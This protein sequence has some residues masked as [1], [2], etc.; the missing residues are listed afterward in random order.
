METPVLG[1]HFDKAAGLQLCNFIKKRFQH[2]CF[3][4]II[5]KFLGI[6]ILRASPNGCFCL[7]KQ[8]VRIQQLCHTSKKQFCKKSISFVK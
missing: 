2:S 8:S 1:S 5:A 6:P 4:V 3:P 7:F